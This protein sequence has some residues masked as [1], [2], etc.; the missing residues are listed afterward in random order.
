MLGGVVAAGVAHLPWP[1]LRKA[2]LGPKL[3]L[4]WSTARLRK[5][6]QARSTETIGSII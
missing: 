6:P 3:G 2:G 1:D 4:D 5:G